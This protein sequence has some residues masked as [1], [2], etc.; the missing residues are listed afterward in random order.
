MSLFDLSAQLYLRN[1]VNII[2]A[3]IK[4]KF[5]LSKREVSKLV[6]PSSPFLYYI[7]VKMSDCG[8]SDGEVDFKPSIDIS[9][10]PIPVQN[11]V[12]ALKNL[13]LKTVQVILLFLDLPP[14]YYSLHEG[15]H[16]KL[17]LFSPCNENLGKPMA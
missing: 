4:I 16:L 6:K 14:P 13:Q 8:S 5:V 9:S 17:L 7:T 2:I 15:Y 3:Y 10:L 12:K 1:I 11:R